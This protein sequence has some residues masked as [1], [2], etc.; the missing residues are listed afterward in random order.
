[1]VVAQSTK[2]KTLDELRQRYESTITALKEKEKHHDIIF[3]TTN[4]PM[5]YVAIEPNDVYRFVSVNRMFATV[6]GYKIE[7][8]E[9]MLIE[10]IVPLNN[11]DLVKSKYKEAITTKSTIKYHEVASLPNGEKTAEVSVVP[12]LNLNDEVTHLLCSAYDLTP[13]KEAEKKLCKKEEL[14]KNI[15]EVLPVAVFCK[16]IINDFKY[17]LI[18]EQTRKFLKSNFKDYSGKSDYD[19]FSVKIANK[20]RKLDLEAISSNEIVEN[21]Q[22]IRNNAGKV[23]Y[24]HTVRTVLLNEEGNPQYVLGVIADITNKKQK[25]ASIK[26]QLTQIKLQNNQLIDFSNIISH[27]LRAPLINLGMLIDLIKK[28]EEEESKEDLID[29]VSTVT[30]NLT[31]TFN[32]LVES[33]QVKQDV[34]ITSE[35]LYIQDVLDHVLEGVQAEIHASDAII[36]TDFTEMDTVI[37]CKKY[38][39]SILHNLI[40]NAIKYR[41]PKRKP[42]IKISLNM[43]F[44]EPVLS[45]QDN[46]LGLDLEKFGANLFRLRKVFHHHPNAKGFG[47]FMVKT[48]VGAMGGRIWAEGEIDKGLTFF[49][50][51]KNKYL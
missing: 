27:N 22:K 7:E 44:D 29:K 32:E 21:T 6:T 8:V 20:H 13:I 15:L 19:I 47:L 17:I 3:N 49:V 18:N 24:V 5:W 36:E 28:T 4:N 10:K 41:S 33:L 16:D 23:K 11:H 31:E 26:R 12:V 14:L 45:V 1:M 38:L 50:K 34:N 42:H 9:G 37:Y 40:S 39:K 46:G 25:E 35:K 43:I 48:Q 51:L 2:E 30:N